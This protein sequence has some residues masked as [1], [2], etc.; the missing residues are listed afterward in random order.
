MTGKTEDWERRAVLRKK[1]Y[2]KHFSFL[3]GK[4]KKI[5]KS[6]VEI[7]LRTVMGLLSA[8]Q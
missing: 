2:T 1:Q 6:E 4:Q 8:I 3:R 5:I 7:F